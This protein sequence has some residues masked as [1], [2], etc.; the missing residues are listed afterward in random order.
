[1]HPFL[2]QVRRNSIVFSVG[3]VSGKCDMPVTN[4][5]D[6]GWPGISEKTCLVKGMC[7]KKW[8]GPWCYRPYGKWLFC[9]INDF[10][11]ALFRLN[12]FKLIH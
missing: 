10:K 5:V 1:M 6:A 9:F 12:P 4:A 11:I 3:L 7:W 8:N 2:L